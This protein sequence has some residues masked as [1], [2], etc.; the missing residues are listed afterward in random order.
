MCLAPFCDG[1]FLTLR[2]VLGVTTKIKFDFIHEL[3]KG[4]DKGN[5]CEQINIV[6]NLERKNSGS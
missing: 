6:H 5:I 4:F 3:E 1:V 2:R